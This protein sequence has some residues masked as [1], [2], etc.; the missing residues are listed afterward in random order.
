MSGNSS[1]KLTSGG[2]GAGPRYARI[3][4]ILETRLRDGTYPI[5]SLMPTEVEL[6]AEFDT[7]RFTVREALRNLT[8]NGFVERRQGLG[9]RVISTQ[10]QVRYSQTFDSLQELF[11]VAVETYYVVLG[12][13][14]ITLDKALAQIVGGKPGEAWTRVNGVRWTRPGGRPLAYIQSYVPA[15]FAHLVPQFQDYNGPFFNLLES[16]SVVP[17]DE[18]EQ[19]ISAA[20]MPEAAQRLLG[21]APGAIALQLLRRYRTSEGVL[22]TSCNWHPA[23]QLSYKMR[24]RRNRGQS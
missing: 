15:A 10:P 7:S 5:G 20:P 13:E 2:E 22:I 12:S 14:V 19:E 9:T 24:I 18:C 11:Q 4:R 17:I 21:L 1:D 3:Q 16:H 8:D 6:S 23:E